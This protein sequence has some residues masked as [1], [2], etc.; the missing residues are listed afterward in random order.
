[1]RVVEPLALERGD[2]LRVADAR[3]VAVRIEHDGGRDDGPGQA[4]AAD[5]VDAGDVD[6]PHAPER[7]LDGAERANLGHGASPGRCA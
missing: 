7:V 6:E 3:H 1:M 5:F 4:A 2:R